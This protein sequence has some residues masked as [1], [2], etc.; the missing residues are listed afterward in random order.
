M[1]QIHHERKLFPHLSL[2][3]SINLFIYFSYTLVVSQYE[4]STTIYYSLRAYSRQRFDLHKINDNF[5]T[6][7]DLSGA[8]TSTTAGGCPNHPQ[9]YKSNPIYKLTVGPKDT[10]NLIIELRAPKVYQVGIEITNMSLEDPTITAP[11]KTH[12]SGNYRSGF[13]F[14]DMENIPAGV[15]CVMVSTFNPG[16]EGPFFLKFKCTTGVKVE[17]VQ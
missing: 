11:F 1:I 7:Q 3:K 12:T 16:Q 17:K 10:S 8:W 4:K 2:Q 14:L 6:N 5:Q 15:Y 9:T 13:C